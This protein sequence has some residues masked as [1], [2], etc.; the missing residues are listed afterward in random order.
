MNARLLGFFS[1]FPARRF[2]AGIARRLGEELTVDTGD[3]GDTLVFISAW[4]A[5]HERNDIESAG[6]HGMFAEYGMAFREHRVIDDRTDPAE[7]EKLIRN[8]SCIF[9][10]GGDASQ[11]FRL[12]CEKGISDPIRQSAAV[13]LGVSAG[14]YN[15]AVRALDIWESDIPY[16]GLGLAD[17][18]VKAHVKPDDRELLDRLSRISSE[19]DLP[20]LAME[21]ESA[22][23][24]KEGEVSYTGRICLIRS[25]EI[26]PLSHELLRQITAE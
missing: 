21:D 1:G 22:V 10:M 23:F 16:A 8:A 15:M 17:I 6:M 20:I 3:T 9:L 26:C 5:D 18:T 19:Q 25:G 14:S 2:P 12:I 13:I 4:P 7:A 11:Q 24:V